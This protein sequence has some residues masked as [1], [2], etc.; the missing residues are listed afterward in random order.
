MRTICSDKICEG[1]TEISILM[2][3]KKKKQLGWIEK[4]HDLYIALL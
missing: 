1:G 2:E 3:M 4:K